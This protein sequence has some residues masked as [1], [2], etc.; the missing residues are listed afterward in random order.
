MFDLS[1]EALAALVVLVV[2]AG[3]LIG[4]TLVFIGGGRGDPQPDQRQP[5][6]QRPS[7]WPTK[8]GQTAVYSTAG[9]PEPR[10]RTSVL[11]IIFVGG[12]AFLGG[13][14]G[15]AIHQSTWAP[16]T[17]LRHL[18][19]SLHCDFAVRVGLA[20]SRAGDPG[21]H[22]RNDGNQN[23]IACETY[24]G[25]LGAVTVMALPPV[26]PGELAATEADLA[27]PAETASV[28]ATQ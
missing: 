16:D 26:S 28:L 24:A 9:A 21:Y 25:G 15:M 4:S 7:D 27:V 17:T 13:S 18:A 11:A 5:G 14:V 6:Y 8:S 19:A 2:L 20:P 12:V 3:S 23:G 22:I 1:F 10:T